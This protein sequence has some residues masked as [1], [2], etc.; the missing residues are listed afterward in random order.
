MLQNISHDHYT[1]LNR[2]NSITNSRNKTFLSACFFYIFFVPQRP[3]NKTK[4]NLNPYF[5]YV[6]DA[7]DISN[8]IFTIS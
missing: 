4:D 3:T 5:P 8:K 7:Y 6:I 1:T 2:N